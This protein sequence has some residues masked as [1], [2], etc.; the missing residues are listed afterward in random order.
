MFLLL[1]REELD[2]LLFVLKHYISKKIFLLKIVLT[3]ILHH[4]IITKSLE[5]ENLRHQL[6]QRKKLKKV[7]DK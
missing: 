1:F 5:A 2:I 3:F 4:V 6:Y 7:V